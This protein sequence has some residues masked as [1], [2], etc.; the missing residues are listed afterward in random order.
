MKQTWMFVPDDNRFH[1]FADWQLRDMAI[2]RVRSLCDQPY[3]NRDLRAVAIGRRCE[4][5]KL[6]DTRQTVAIG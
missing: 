6:E 4:K 1:L 2:S 3:P 5:C